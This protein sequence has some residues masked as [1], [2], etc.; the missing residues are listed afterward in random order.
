VSATLQVRLRSNV[1]RPEDIE[2]LYWVGCCVSAD[3][4][5]SSV[6]RAVVRI[7]NAAG[8][9][10]AV[11]GGEEQ[12]CGDPARRTGNEFHFATLARQNIETLQRYGT[13]RILAHCP[14]CLHV[15]RNEYP[16]FGGHFEVIHHSE[17]IR[18][19][20]ESG[21]LRL[22]E[23]FAGSLTY[24]DPCYLARYNAVVSAPRQVLAAAGARPVEMARAREQ[25][26]CCGGGG[27]HLFFESDG[28]E[29]INRIRARE[30]IA[31][32][33]ETVCTACPYC[34]QMMEDGVGAEGA[35]GVAVR[36]IAEVV[37]GLT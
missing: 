3:D 30:A 6:A 16:R 35:P 17:L 36:D 8:V 24:H 23:R 26:F 9:R 18:D 11:L 37:A 21:R 13:T 22:S 1:G 27:G 28:G 4:R 15:L 14:H 20:I 7:L 34:L 12:C 25:T 32:H 31:T 33:C 10:F 2:L 29:R 19:L 5:V